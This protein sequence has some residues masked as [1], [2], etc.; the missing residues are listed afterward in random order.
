MSSPYIISL[1][2]E[3]YWNTRLLVKLKWHSASKN[4]PLV[5]EFTKGVPQY[6]K[7][8]QKCI[9]QFSDS[10]Y[11]AIVDLD[12]ESPDSCQLN[13][14]YNL[15]QQYRE[16]FPPHL[17]RET[18]GAALA[19]LQLGLKDAIKS[20]KLKP[21][22]KIILYAGGLQGDK[23]MQGL[24]DYYSHL[25]LKLVS[26]SDC[27]AKRF[28]LMEGTVDTILAKPVTVHPWVQ[29]ALDLVPQ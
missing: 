21:N 22:A 15:V 26:K 1:G 17:V 24:V 18:K 25:G 12:I 4:K 11:A 28:C 14:F 29:K 8:A 7:T 6:D 20:G 27:V 3:F 5:K 13:F 19:L 2:Y 16:N 23:D 9:D 10:I